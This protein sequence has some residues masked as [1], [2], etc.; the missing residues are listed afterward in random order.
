MKP[1]KAIQSS[2]GT[3]FQPVSYPE[4]VRR[5]LPDLQEIETPVWSFVL[6]ARNGFEQG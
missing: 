2:G 5:K 3:G 4:A 1:E 6:F